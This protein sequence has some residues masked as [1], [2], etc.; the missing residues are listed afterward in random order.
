MLAECQDYL[1]GFGIIHNETGAAD[2][3]IMKW[4]SAA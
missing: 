4:D 1:G 3:R 2:N